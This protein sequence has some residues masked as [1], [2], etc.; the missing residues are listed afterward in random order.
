MYISEAHPSDGRQAPANERD[1][2]VF[3]QPTAL[4]ERA[5]IAKACLD[6][7]K[8]TMPCVLDDME[9]TTE[10]AYGG[11]PDRICIVDLAGKVAYYGAPGP[12]GFRP[13]EAEAA[14]ETLLANMAR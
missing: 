7:M 14:L 11:W 5:D 3:R 6:S 9:N 10:R 8:L 1:G 13:Q 4:A 12:G 2:V